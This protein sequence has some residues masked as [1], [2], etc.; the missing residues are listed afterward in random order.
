[1]P[2]A[3]LT[4]RC[5]VAGSS[6]RAKARRVDIMKEAQE[7]V[8]RRVRAAVIASLLR[9]SSDR[10]ATSCWAWAFSPDLPTPA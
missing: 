4:L 9:T 3:A 1:M 5:F 6:A 10:G 8:E 2:E 7:I